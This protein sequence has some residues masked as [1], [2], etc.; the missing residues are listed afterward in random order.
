MIPRL[1]LSEVGISEPEKFFTTTNYTKNHALTLTQIIDGKADMGAFGSEEYH[2][3]LAKDPT[4]DNKVNLL[5]ESSPIPL[6]PVLF[7]KTLPA[8]ISNE[9]Q[10]SLLTLHEKNV[11]ALE[12]VKSGWT[13]AIPAERFQKVDESYYDTILQGNREN[14]MRIVKQFAQ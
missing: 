1:K 2:R 9:L 10:K 4:L 13:E 3:L 6:G 12:S 11:N 7:D 14:G 5:W 8:A